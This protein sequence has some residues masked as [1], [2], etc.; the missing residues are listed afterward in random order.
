MKVTVKFPSLDTR[1]SSADCKPV[2]AT[3]RTGMLNTLSIRS[4][5]QIKLSHNVIMIWLIYGRSLEANRASKWQD[6]YRGSPYNRPWRP[7]VSKT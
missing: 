2:P 7:Y 5:G 4:V 6:D 1:L 3:Y